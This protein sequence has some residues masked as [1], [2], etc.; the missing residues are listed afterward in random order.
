MKN[1]VEV[2]EALLESMPPTAAIRNLGKM[3]A[4]GLLQPMSVASKTLTRKLGDEA[5]LR[6]QRVHPMSILLGMKV[7]E[8]GHGDKGKLTWSPVR[9]VLDALD[10]AFYLSFPNIEP[11]RKRTL[12]AIDIS[13][14]MDSSCVAGTVLSARVAAG[15]M[16][17]VTARVEE[18]WHAVGFT[19]G[20]RGEYRH[21]KCTSMHGE[22]RYASNLSEL[23]ISPK[24]RLDEIVKMMHGLPLGGTNCALPMMYAM[25]RGMGIDVFHVYT[26]NE[27]WAGELHPHEALRMYRE[28]TGIAAKLI[29]VGMTATEFTIADPTDAGML[30][31][32]GLDAAAPAIM[33]DFAR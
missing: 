30:D 9:E 33:A 12:L 13:G 21:P 1:R 31:V 19:C 27:T 16:A 2:W 17:M 7:Y 15:A 32:V 14:S 10:G 24:Q 25:D 3:T 22:E 8:Q 26:D 6:K 18:A 28:K 5:L 20:V 29:V 11:S 4:V 23:K